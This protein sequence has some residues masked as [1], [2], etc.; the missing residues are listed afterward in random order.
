MTL[1][2][3]PIASLLR[4]IAGARIL[5]LGDFM[6]DRTIYGVASRISPEAPSPVILVQQTREQLGGA[7]NVVRNLG[8]LGGKVCCVAVVGE[9]EAGRTLED[10]LR[11]SHGCDSFQVIREAGRRTTVKTRIRSGLLALRD[12]LSQIGVEQ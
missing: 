4:Q 3:P 11:V 2:R 10:R 6:L 5:V 7:G 9:D 8:T 1:E 12:L